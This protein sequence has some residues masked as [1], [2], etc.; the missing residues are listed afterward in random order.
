MAQRNPRPAATN[1]QNYNQES[2]MDKLSDYIIEPMAK[3]F[4]LGIR[5]LGPFF[6]IALYCL[7]GLHVYAFFTVI[8][9]VLKKRLG[10]LFGMTWVGIGLSILYNLCFNH[11]LA[12]MIKPGS[13]TD[14]KRIE[15]LRKDIKKRESRRGI[16]QEVA[17]EDG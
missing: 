11:F 3:G 15:S 7:V 17:G 12:M 14:L 10:T 6:C 13:P 1:N 9:M 8:L 2:W 4:G 16:T 5:L